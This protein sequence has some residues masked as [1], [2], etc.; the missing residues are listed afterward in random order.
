MRRPDFSANICDSV[1]FI[2]AST[3]L[4]PIMMDHLYSMDDTLKEG[5]PLLPL[6]GARQSCKDDE[7]VGSLL[8]LTASRLDITFGVRL[9]SMFMEAPRQSHM[10]AVKRILRY[11]KD[12]QSDG[13]FYSSNCGFDLVGYADNDWARDVDAKSTSGYA[14]HIGSGVI[15][16]SSKME[17]VVALSS[18]EA[19]YNVTT[20]YATHAVWMR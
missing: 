5:G 8:Y 19:E 2:M 6:E 13:I 4:P 20:Y 11:V 12:T 9:I 1:T 10:Q 16:W 17:Q 7:L 15:S 14:F 3:D 18:T